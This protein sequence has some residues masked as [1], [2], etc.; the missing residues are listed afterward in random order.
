MGIGSAALA[1]VS[2]RARALGKDVLQLQV[3]KSDEGSRS[4]LEHRGFQK[5][6]GEE[7]V[8]LRLEAPQEPSVPPDGIRLFSRRERPEAVEAMYEV[9]VEC[10]KDVP[11]SSGPLTLEGWRALDI[12]RPTR[13]PDL[14]FVAFDG[15]EV[16]GYAVADFFGDEGHHGFTA[17][18]R[19]WR[20]RGVATALKRAQ[21]A[22]A[23][24]LGLTLLIT[25][26]EER[27]VPMRSLNAKLGY[28]PDP[29]RS[30]VILQGPLQ[31]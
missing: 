15:D 25:G 13:S 31:S 26:S 14:A 11:G 21:I 23:T 5:V 17:V 7:A 24:E 28:R 6:G 3:V 20:R 10:D 2:A 18:K 1:D 4:F 19:A 29:E 12:D 22:A 9:Y 27:N 16:V 30:V 8:S